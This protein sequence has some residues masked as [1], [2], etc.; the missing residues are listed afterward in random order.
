[1]KILFRGKRIDNKEW[2]YGWYTKS[3]WGDNI[4][5]YIVQINFPFTPIKAIPETVVQFTGCYDKNKKMI[6]NGDKLSYKDDSGT[7]QI[8]IVKYASAHYYCE[9]INGDDE[10]NQDGNLQDIENECELIS[11]KEKINVYR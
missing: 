7:Q 2:V 1:M 3:K 5:D 10:G 4:N 9:A 6:F 11:A 8:G